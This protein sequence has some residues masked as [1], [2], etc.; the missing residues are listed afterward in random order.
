MNQ[1]IGNLFL[2]HISRSRKDKMNYYLED[3]LP[4]LDWGRLKLLLNEP[5]IMVMKMMIVIMI[6]L[7]TMLS[8]QMVMNHID[9]KVSVTI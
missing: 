3:C 1:L 4:L 6:I 9:G 5:G 7:I 8:M 2:Y